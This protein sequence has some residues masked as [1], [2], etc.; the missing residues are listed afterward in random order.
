MAVGLIVFVF[1]Y[2]CNFVTLLSIEHLS[3][4]SWLFKM[5]ACA[6]T[7]TFLSQLLS[8]ICKWNYVYQV[9]KSSAISIA[10]LEFVSN[11]V[12]LFLYCQELV[13]LVAWHKAGSCSL[14]FLSRHWPLWEK[15]AEPSSQSSESLFFNLDSQV[16][17]IVGYVVFCWSS[18]LKCVSGQ[19]CWISYSE[20]CNSFEVV[21]LRP[22]VDGILH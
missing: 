11:I 19:V 10:K 17:F 14:N 6:R 21:M 5:C 12:N 4:T 16:S 20:F 9:V 7:H 15:W 3:V 22:D 8:T 2:S 13:C 18:S 1:V